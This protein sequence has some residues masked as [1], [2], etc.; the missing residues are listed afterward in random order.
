MIVERVGTC[1]LNTLLLRQ[2][3][4]IVR[5]AAQEA[6]LWKKRS[7]PFL[8]DFKLRVRERERKQFERQRVFSMR[9]RKSGKEEVYQRVAMNTYNLPQRPTRAAK[10]KQQEL[11]LVYCSDLLL[12]AQN[13]AS[14]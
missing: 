1:R 6:I 10:L 14:D 2:L 7:A 8:A 9:G 4:V 13:A 11:A 12:S 3:K 5:L